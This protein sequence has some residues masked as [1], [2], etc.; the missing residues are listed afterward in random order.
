M[1]LYEDYGDFKQPKKPKHKCPV[2]LSE[3]I[4]DIS[5]YESNGIIGHGKVSWK[6]SDLRACNNCGVVFMPT[7]GN[8]ID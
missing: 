5:T 7:E 1:D 4:K 3:D 8:T 2:C 6:T